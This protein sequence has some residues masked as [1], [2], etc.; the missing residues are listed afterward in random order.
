MM[1]NIWVRIKYFFWSRWFI[2]FKL[3]HHVEQAKEEL[4]ADYLTY[5]LV[6]IMEYKTPLSFEDWCGTVADEWIEE[7]EKAEAAYQKERSEEN[8]H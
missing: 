2:R 5:R 7:I 1:S 4:E 8:E 6:S 3:P